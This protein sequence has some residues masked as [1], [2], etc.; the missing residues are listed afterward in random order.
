FVY[1]VQMFLMATQDDTF[2]RAH[3][4][5]VLNDIISWHV[6]GTRHGIHADDDGLLVA[7]PA[8]RPLTWMDVKMGEWIVT[9]RFGKPVEIQ[10]LWYN[11]LRF[12]ERLANR[13]GDEPRGAE[14]DA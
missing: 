6:R 7:G 13:Y 2:V 11:A 9:P 8:E 5:D 1:A 12:M 14:L 4:Y 10:A 3:L